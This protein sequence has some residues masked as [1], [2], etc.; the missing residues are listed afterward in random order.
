MNEAK[1]DDQD[2]HEPSGRLCCP[3]LNPT[4]VEAVAAAIKAGTVEELDI[5]IIKHLSDGEQ[6]IWIRA[7]DGR[8]YT[9]TVEE[10]A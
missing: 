4:F 2:L 10:L 3:E 6:E 7:E 1:H 5:S 8:H 9:V